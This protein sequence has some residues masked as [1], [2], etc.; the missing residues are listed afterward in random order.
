VRLQDYRD[1]PEDELFDKISSVGMFEHVGR[2]NLPVYFA[3]INRLLRPGG[4]V[5]NHGITNNSLEDAEL[6][7]GIGEFVDE[8]VFPGGEL[9]HVTS[10]MEEMSRQGLEVWDAECLRPHYARTLWHWVDRLEA[11]RGQA[12]DLVGEKRLRTWLIYMAG[13]AH[14]F[15]RGWISIYQLLG[16]KMQPDGTVP[17]PSTREHVYR[18]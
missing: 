10:V 2:R 12:R 4:L 18:G 8:Y 16:I 6:G 5:M 9:M 1:I 13:S 17:Y 15:A 14:A 7:G 11:N 3:K